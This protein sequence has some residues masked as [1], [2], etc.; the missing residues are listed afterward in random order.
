MFNDKTH[1]KGFTLV[2]LLVALLI[3]SVAMLGIVPALIRSMQ[4]NLENSIRDNGVFVMNNLVNDLKGQDYSVV[5]SN[6]DNISINDVMYKREW[7]VLDNAS[8]KQVAVLVTWTNPYKTGT[9]NDNASA[10]FFIK[11]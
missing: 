5:L 10:V 11:E 7:V 4:K 6:Q 2:E 9:Y 3:F 8:V 1:S